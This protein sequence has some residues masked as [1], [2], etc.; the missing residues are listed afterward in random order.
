MRST[1][2]TSKERFI[3]AAIDEIKQRGIVD[4][5]IR[6]IAKKCNVSCGAPYKHFKSKNDIILAVIDYINGQWYKRQ[7]EIMNSSPDDIVEQLLNISVGYIVFLHEH[8]EF[9]TILMM[10]DNTIDSDH[11]SEKAMLSHL[12]QKLVTEYCKMVNMNK[13]DEIRKTYVVRALIFGA[14]IMLNSGLME[15][16]DDTLNMMRGCIHREF[17]LA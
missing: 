6:S 7:D 4:F 3:I 10:N 14:A 2:D 8:P 1:D 17:N 16:N 12:S 5:S 15:C 11:R 13:E 9:Q